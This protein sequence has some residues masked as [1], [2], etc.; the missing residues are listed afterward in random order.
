M[1]SLNTN[2]DPIYYS[3]ENFLKLKYNQKQN[4]RQRKISIHNSLD[5][6]MSVDLLP[7]DNLFLSLA[8]DKRHNEVAKNISYDED[9]EN[10]KKKSKDSTK[11]K[12]E[13][14][15]QDKTYNDDIVHILKYADENNPHS[16]ILEI[17]QRLKWS[18]PDVDSFKINENDINVY[19]TQVKLKGYMG[20][21]IGITK[22]ISKSKLAI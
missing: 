18:Y 1:E 4:S 20:A 22:K 11:L 10:F 2:K 9:K 13:K 14:K 19:K 17:C 5:D 7:N 21:G 15:G 3:Q 6:E 12:L 16:L 8:R